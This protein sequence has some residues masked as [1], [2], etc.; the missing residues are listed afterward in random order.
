[1]ADVTMGSGSPMPDS[2]R[3]SD[4]YRTMQ[5]LVTD[6]IRT[7]VLDGTFRPHQKLNQ[8]ML[9]QKLQVS[10]IPTREALRILEGE[11]LVTFR[12][13]QGAMVAG[14]SS[15]EVEEVYEIRIMLETSAALRAMKRM[16][17]EDVRRMRE[18]QREMVKSSDLDA[19]VKLNDH[20]HQ[21]ILAPSGWNRLLGVIQL[22]R[23]LT[24]PYVRLYLADGW[25]R[26]SADSE[27]SGIVGALEKKDGIALKATMRKHLAHSC[28]EII[29]RMREEVED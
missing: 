2:F 20:F 16:K 5:Q 28:Q 17:N 3:I 9:A 22:L 7:A 14:M 26:R 18:I 23:N 11:G 6:K 29:S 25:D 19:W 15:E 10:R 27:H 1:M 24:T 21:A 12:P 13:H 8:A 4:D